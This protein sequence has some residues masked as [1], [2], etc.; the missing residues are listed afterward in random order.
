MRR[1]SAPELVTRPYRGQYDGDSRV[2]RRSIQRKALS[3]TRLSPAASDCRLNAWTFHTDD[4]HIDTPA[5]RRCFA[6]SAKNES[7]TTVVPNSRGKQVRAREAVGPDQRRSILAR[8]APNKRPFN[9]SASWTKSTRTCA[10]GAIHFRNSLHV[11]HDMG[12]EIAAYLVNNAFK[13][14]R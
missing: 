9:T 5:R 4:S 13:P 3:R 14:V 8:S 2:E 10:C 11:G 7:S 1:T 12:K 6:R